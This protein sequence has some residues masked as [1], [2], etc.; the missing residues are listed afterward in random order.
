MTL[1]I[2]G[3]S[4]DPFLFW[5]RGNSV[6][7]AVDFASSNA[8]TLARLGSGAHVRHLGKRPAKVL[9]LYEREGCPYCR[10]V[11]EALS[12]LDLN[13]I[14]HPC[15]EGGTRFRAKVE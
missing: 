1:T 8:A 3:T 2:M 6:A 12:I 15:P 10:K 11:R 9:E 13:A 7:E 5:K 4:L 14:I